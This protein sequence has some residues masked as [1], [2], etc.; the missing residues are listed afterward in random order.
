MGVKFLFFSHF[1]LGRRRKGMVT[2]H[3]ESNADTS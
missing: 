3:A 1:E 2:L